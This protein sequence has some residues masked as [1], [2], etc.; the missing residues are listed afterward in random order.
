MRPLLIALAVLLG[1]GSTGHAQDDPQATSGVIPAGQS[2][3]APAPA[4]S[5]S[6]GGPEQSDCGQCRA[7]PSAALSPDS[8]S[9]AS[10]IRLCDGRATSRDYRNEYDAGHAI[11]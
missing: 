6:V 2:A 10:W 11:S 1:L 7:R 3:P 5:D 8:H 9:G 4:A